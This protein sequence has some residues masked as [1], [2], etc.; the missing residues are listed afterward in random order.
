M[1][2]D[3]KHLFKIGICYWTSTL[4]LEG[5]ISF[6]ERRYVLNLIRRNKP[7]L[8]KIGLQGSGGYYWEMGNIVPRIKWLKKHLR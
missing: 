3:N 1:F 8:T 2:L 5:V 4:Y 6:E 7:A